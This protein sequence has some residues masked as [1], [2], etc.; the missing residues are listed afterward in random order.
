MA[1]E[2][3]VL[4]VHESLID[5]IYFSI[6]VFHKGIYLRHLSEVFIFKAHSPNIMIS[7]HINYFAGAARTR[8]LLYQGGVIISLNYLGE[9]DFF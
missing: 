7:L 9:V 3:F 2:L 5:I 6:D 4:I 8:Y 1:Q